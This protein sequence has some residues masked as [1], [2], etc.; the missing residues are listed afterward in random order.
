MTSS[1]NHL[2]NNNPLVGDLFN[3]LA[4]E[5][6]EEN[7]DI[8]LGDRE[9][10]YIELTNSESEELSLIE[11]M[12]EA[13]R[14]DDDDYEGSLF[15]NRPR[16]FSSNYNNL[17]S[18]SYTGTDDDFSVNQDATD[19][20]VND[21]GS[22]VT[23][24]GT[25]LTG[26]YFDKANLSKSILTRTDTNID[27]DW[28][29]GSPDPA[30]KKNTFSVRWT[31]QIE[32]TQNET[33]TFYTQ[34]DDGVRL[35]VN[36]EL[37]IDDWKQHSRQERSGT[38][39]LEAG[40][41][42]DI[43]LEYFE[44]KGSASVSLLWSSP[45]Q[46]KEIIPTSFLYPEGY[47]PPV[48]TPTD[49][50]ITVPG[51][52]NE[53]ITATLSLVSKGGDYNNEAGLFLVDDETG[54]IGNLNPGDEG[55]AAAAL[56]PE[57]RLL[58]L[59]SGQQATETNI[60]GGSYVGSYLI[61][62]NTT[63]AFLAHNPQND[64]HSNPVA[65]FN[66]TNTNPDNFDHLESSS[67]G[68]NS[69]NLAWEDLRYG[70]DK[71][72][73]DLIVKVDFAIAPEPIEPIPPID[74]DFSIVAEGEVRVNGSSDFDGD[75]ADYSDDAYIYA[76]KGFTFN[77]NL[78]LPV[79][80]DEAGNSIT[81]S[82]NKEV[83]LDNA[84]AVSSNYLYANANGNNTNRYSGLVPPTVV[85]TQ[86]VSVPD[87]HD[88]LSENLFNAIPTDAEVIDFNIR[89]NRMN[90]QSQWQHKFPAPGTPDHPTVVK[91]I[92]GGLNIPSHV[93]LS[94]YVI[95]VEH[96][97]INF[98]GSGHD[99]DNVVL[100]AQNGSINLS[101]VSAHN[102]SVFA[103][104]TINMNGQAR[105]SGESLV[106]NGHGNITF[107]GATATTEES[108]FLTVIS[109]GNITFNGSSDTRG[110]FL[111]AKDFT[112]NG[113]STL[114]GSIGAKKNITFN[115]NGTV[116]GI[117]PPVVYPT[118]D[119][120][121]ED[122][123]IVEG[124]V[125][126]KI[127]QFSVT[128]SNPSQEAVTI[129]YATQ[130]L[131]AIGGQ[132]YGATSGTVTFEPGEIS[133]TIQ[134]P[135]IGDSLD[136]LDK[137]FVVNLSNP[138]NAN[139]IDDSGQGTIEDNDDAPA[140]SISSEL[141]TEGDT[142][143]KQAEFTVMLSN[144]SG[145]EISVDFNTVEGTALAGIDYEAIA[146]TL[147]FAPGEI[148]K[149]ITVDILGDNL[150]EVDEAFSIELANPNNV[151]L[152]NNLAT[153][154]IIDNDLPPEIT[155][156]N[157]SVTEGDNGTSNATIT[158]NLDRP[159]SLP[160]S[161]DYATVNDTAIAGEDYNAIAGTVDF[162][163]GET[164]KTI[165]IAIAGDT[166]DEFN[167]NF[168]IN[169]TNASNGTIA[170][171]TSTVT[172][173]DDDALA[174]VSVGDVTL[175]EGDEGSTNASFTV[176]LD[177]PSTKPITI[178]F[179]TV[180]GTGIA[181][182][183]YV[184]VSGQLEFAPGE[185]SKTIEVAVLGDKLDEVDEAFTIH[186]SNP[187]NADILNNHGT[188]TIVNDDNPPT[189]TVDNLTITEGDSG[190]AEAI[191]TVSLSEA[192]GKEITLDYSTVDGDA[193]A[194]EDYE[195]I[196]G[197][198]TFAPGE[199]TKTIAVT[200]N[201]DNL[202]ELDEAFFLQIEN[203]VNVAIEE[204]QVT[205]TIVDNDNPPELSIKDITV[206]EGNDGTNVAIF[207]VN[208][209]NP[210]SQEITIDYATADGSAIAGED[211]EA[212][213]GTVTFA[214]GETTKTIEVPLLGD[215]I[216]EFNES[217]SLN[218]SNGN[219]VT[220]TDSQAIANLDDNDAAPNLTVG[221][222]SVTEG[223]N[224]ITNAS[225]TINLDNPSGKEI[226]VD[227]SSLDGNAVSG[228][229]YE[230]IAGKVTFAPGETS[231]TVEI[232]IN[233]DILNETD[234]TFDIQLTNPNNAS[235]ADDLTT[236]TIVNDDL[237]PE[238]TV[239]DVTVDE[240]SN[241][242][243]VTVTLDNPSS[244]E[245]SI[246]YSTADGS[247]IDG[248]DYTAIAGSLIFAPGET[249]KTI[250]VT[251]LGDNIDEIDE[252]FSINLTNPNN[253]TVVDSQAIVNLTDNDNPPQLAISDVTVTEGDSGTNTASFTVTLDNPS[254]KEITIGDKL[255]KSTSCQTKSKC[256]GQRF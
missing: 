214:P 129:D 67:A 104:K 14:Q 23:A 194:G 244:K 168:G 26:E 96:G 184:G 52:S 24:Q 44:K 120:S 39:D 198:L 163:P 63:E 142:G 48:T 74:L 32:A 73:D 5:L 228:E 13:Q 64:L 33:Y 89:H 254:G 177:V 239:T 133:Q 9:G 189:V 8:G 169:L 76:G 146:G 156:E 167:E 22:E 223:D 246:D 149:T 88:L 249:T 166:I 236:I 1:H 193:V 207:T 195:A 100:V 49:L 238:L 148:S 28:H 225:F 221:D 235:L 150:D 54:R 65:F 34:A 2:G 60:P 111:T 176:S 185:T 101:K 234:E 216:D 107:D 218:L 211:Y 138:S 252:A 113:H 19:S 137:E 35:W 143:I 38:I 135:I 95:I 158:I 105:F 86:T 256:R 43:K 147:T 83:L 212:I 85:D 42:Y 172:I 154:T 178:D 188:G 45:S 220:I 70:G 25:G 110:E 153:G 55:Y 196:A 204:T 108:D 229:D 106:A 7:V 10:S 175:V 20:Q 202:D 81:D 127:A 6:G 230:A 84:V 247:A 12:M 215:S 103:S 41:F 141:V 152:S 57:R 117:A 114:Y 250:E 126:T 210:S 227:Y 80:R 179:T 98:N 159:S 68:E 16:S 224:G 237:L 40:E 112:F 231:K 240:D 17:G 182:E 226:T 206:T 248:K 47:V 160:V 72:F 3:P 31:G 78:E 161:V 92:G 36:N 255:R 118:P 79:L 241:S 90:N 18:S 201:G 251:L 37:I 145:K 242:V 208:L 99:L 66:F 170:T 77:G 125:G 192:S 245:I 116:I 53:E 183:D 56:A 219:N 213:V 119:V 21:F 232:A 140:L 199:T 115:G 62:N 91:V 93:D 243:I 155:I 122:I 82:D 162:A 180:D 58:V 29:K 139:I 69:V 132:D 75:P 165:N 233:G 173:L 174:M 15:N 128:L 87:Y 200:V 94:N 134:V 209:D 11:E 130:D 51:E 186:L 197:T 190:T 144:P 27:F 205:G 171:T 50:A 71:D 181:G 131:T 124:D 187:N 102:S 203:G 123:T 4:P 151:T 59:R 217:F 46:A 30:I 61:Q 164:S 121:I 97:N 109:A 253:V 136:E 157:I 222:V 191:F